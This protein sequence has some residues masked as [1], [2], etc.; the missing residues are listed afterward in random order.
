MSWNTQV[1]IICI[2]KEGEAMRVKERLN[3]VVD[4][5]VKAKFDRL[6]Y[7]KGVNGT[8]FFIM[9][10]NDSFERNKDVLVKVYD[11]QQEYRQNEAEHKRKQEELK[12][13]IA[14]LMQE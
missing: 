1:A 6:A 5:D 7:A 4:A 11:L 9:L 12:K 13:S 10:V 3:F 8:Q 2:K 14:S